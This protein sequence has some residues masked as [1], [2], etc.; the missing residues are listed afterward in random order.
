MIRQWIADAI[1]IIAIIVL[2]CAVYAGL[3]WD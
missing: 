1:G 3:S 2:V